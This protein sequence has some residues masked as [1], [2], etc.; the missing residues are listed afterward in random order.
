MRSPPWPNIRPQRRGPQQ[1]WSLTARPAVTVLRARR[2]PLNWGN[3]ENP[4]AACWDW[5]P[6]IHI[7]GNANVQSGG[8]GQGVLLVDGDLDLRGNF[9]FYGIVI[10]QGS[11][12]T[13]GSGNRV[14][15]GVM[16]SNADLEHSVAR[17]R[18]RG[19]DFNVCRQPRHSSKIRASPGSGLWQL[20]VG[21]ICR[22][23]RRS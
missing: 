17:R 18:I 4:G 6:V 7:T 14:Y 16:A 5:F 12:G 22:Q 13:Q 3:P 8:V 2:F 21:S 15:G 19:L 1:P 9:A 20:G 23:S 10:V 11:L